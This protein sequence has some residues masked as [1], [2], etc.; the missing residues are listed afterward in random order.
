[1]IIHDL[2]KFIFSLKHF[3]IQHDKKKLKIS[4]LSEIVYI[5]AAFENLKRSSPSYIIRYV[6]YNILYVITFKI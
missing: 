5:I 6:T 2:F 4:E 3:I 1:M